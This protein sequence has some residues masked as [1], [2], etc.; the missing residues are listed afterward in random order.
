MLSAK[1]YT[2]FVKLMGRTASHIALE[3]ALKTHP[4]YC[5]IGE[6][7][8]NNHMSL[9]DII[10]EITDLIIAR[11]LAGKDY[12]IILV[13]EGLLEFIPECKV[14]I[15]ELNTILASNHI[16]H[17]SNVIEKLTN[18]SKKSLDSF[19]KEIRNNYF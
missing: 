4:N 19:P 9:K 6:E 14:L 17:I 11:S 15:Q 3:C 18:P 2:F 8:A 13:P 5:L 1:K 7:V 12:G 10:K 16:L